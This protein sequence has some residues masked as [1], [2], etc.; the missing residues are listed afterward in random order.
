MSFDLTG[1]FNTWNE[2]FAWTLSNLPKSHIHIWKHALPITF[3][4]ILV[5]EK[6][7]VKYLKQI[8]DTILNWAVLRKVI[9]KAKLCL[10]LEHYIY[11]AFTSPST[12]RLLYTSLIWPI[13][14]YGCSIRG[15]PPKT[16]IYKIKILQ[17][18]IL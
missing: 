11:F 5:L 7:L 18:R 15:S 17:N 3:K 9:K 4:G 1:G 6:Q 12:R 8:L 2:E 16:N 13:W 14:A 10:R